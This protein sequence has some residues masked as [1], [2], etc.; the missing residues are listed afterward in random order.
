MAG[1]CEC[2]PT[3]VNTVL[4]F[5]TVAVA[6]HT[7]NVNSMVIFSYKKETPMIKSIHYRLHEPHYSRSYLI[8]R[9]V[10]ADGKERINKQ[11]GEQVKQGTVTGREWVEVCEERVT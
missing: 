10:V 4:F 5:V 8:T 6:L 1:I 2:E 11:R 7:S 9:R 3:N